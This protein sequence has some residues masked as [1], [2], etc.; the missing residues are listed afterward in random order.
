M[1]KYSTQNVHFY[2]M[3][4][5]KKA[6]ITCCNCFCLACPPVFFFFEVSGEPNH[7]D[8]ARKD[9]RRDVAS[10]LCINMASATWGGTAWLSVDSKKLQLS[11]DIL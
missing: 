4:Y 6:W 11:S 1:N 5:K 3:N 8:V 7:N 2:I 9:C 10:G